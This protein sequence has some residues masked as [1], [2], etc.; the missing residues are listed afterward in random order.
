MASNLRRECILEN[1]SLDHI[2]FTFFSVKKAK[3]WQCH[4]VQHKHMGFIRCH[5]S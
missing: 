4:T 3:Y 1:V 2:K 5:V